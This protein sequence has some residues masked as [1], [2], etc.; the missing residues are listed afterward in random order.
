[1][2]YLWEW[3][4]FNKL[5]YSK[6]VLWGWLCVYDNDLIYKYCKVLVIWSIYVLLFIVVL[7]LFLLF[8]IVVLSFYLVFVCLNLLLRVFGFFVGFLYMLFL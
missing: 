1:M 7:V 4:M 2:N 5:I 6:Y 8:F 3:E